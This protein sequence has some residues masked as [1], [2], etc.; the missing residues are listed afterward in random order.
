MS[1]L[2]R[3]EL[4]GVENLLEAAAATLHKIKPLEEIGNDRIAALR[5]H[6]TRI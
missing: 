3:L 5:G 1:T 6:V 2:F 4:I